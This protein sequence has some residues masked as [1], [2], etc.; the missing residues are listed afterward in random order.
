MTA[1]G[2]SHRTVS[3]NGIK[4]H[5]A[6]QGDGPLVVLCH[7]FPESWYSWRHQMAALA[8]AG[9][10]AVAPDQR[11]Y[12][13]T[14]RPPEARQYTI[15]HLVGD[16]VGLLDALGERNAVIVG[17]DWGAPVAWNAALMR[18]DRFTAVAGL[19]VPYLP[20]AAINPL[21]MLRQFAGDN[22]YMVYFQ[23]PGRAEAE[24]EGDVRGMLRRILVAA[25]GDAAPDQRW[26]PVITPGT[27]F[28]DT[29]APLP[30]LPAWLTEQDLDFVAGEFSRTGFTGGLNWYRAMDMNWELTAPF[31]N[32][33]IAQPS[34]FIAGKRTAS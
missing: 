6:E 10:H 7:G 24:F 19:S 3:T 26:K 17:H 34:L 23:E 13:Q 16:I 20:R 5:V 32:A 11:G 14:D 4:M 33:P 21:T 8:A 2:L 12:G 30:P 28:L 27:G 31:A 22:F 9:Y 29:A 25:S 15:L 1:P 18:P